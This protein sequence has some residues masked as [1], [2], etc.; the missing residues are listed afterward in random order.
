MSLSESP[1]DEDVKE[2]DVKEEDVREET[3][4]KEDVIE[5]IKV[6]SENDEPLFLSEQSFPRT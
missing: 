6:S 1:R 5:T 3:T 2:E 4:K